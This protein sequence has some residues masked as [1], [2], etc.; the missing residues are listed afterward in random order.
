MHVDS[1]VFND[2]MFFGVFY[3]INDIIKLD[4][5]ITGG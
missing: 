5:F 4:V 1:F 3:Q 2:G